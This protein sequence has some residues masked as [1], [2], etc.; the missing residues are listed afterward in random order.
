MQITWRFV[1]LT[2]AATAS[3]LSAYRWSLTASPGIRAEAIIGDA[4]ASVVAYA[5]EVGKPMVIE[6]LDF[7][8]KKAALE[9]ESPASTAGCCPAFSYG[10]IK[11]CFLSRG[12]PG[13]RGSA[14][15]KPGLQLGDWP[16]E[17]HGALRAQRAPG[18][19]SGAGPSP[20]RLLRAHP[21]SMGCSRRQWRTGRLH[22]T[23]KEASEARVDELGCRLAGQLRPAL[24]AQHR[25]GKRRR[26]PNPV[27][28]GTAGNSARACGLNGDPF[29][30]PW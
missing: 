8:Q 5:R 30:V 3:T 11:A 24:A 18:S 20:A 25:L 7:R 23:C 27:Q 6:K 1:K 21:A 29:G 13:G 26:R 16:G 2:P 14:P 19:G 4:V 9:G 15:G 28:A 12:L 10:K 22:R 17:V